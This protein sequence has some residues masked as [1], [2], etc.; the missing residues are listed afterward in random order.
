M[1]HF[2]VCLALRGYL[3]EVQTGRRLC[4]NPYKGLRLPTDDDICQ[5]GTLLWHIELVESGEHVFRLMD[6]TFLT[7]SPVNL[8]AHKSGYSS[9]GAS[10]T[11]NTWDQFYVLPDPYFRNPNDKQSNQSKDEAKYFRLMC[12]GNAR[13]LGTWKNDFYAIE[14]NK[15][16]ATVFKFEEV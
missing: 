3:V 7:V 8:R 1:C 6:G 11:Q 12:V 4:V 16:K 9:G 13:F 14:G 15:H 2:N 5:K 10:F